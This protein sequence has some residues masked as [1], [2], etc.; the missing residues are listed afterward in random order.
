MSKE[1]N[2]LKDVEMEVQV[3]LGRTNIK[4]SQAL[5]LTKGKLLMLDKLSGESVE[6]VVNNKAIGLGEVIV[7]DNNFGVRITELFGTE[8]KEE[9]KHETQVKV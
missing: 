5:E 8:S 6:I 2:F 7:S 3:V 9:Q 4:V 1:L